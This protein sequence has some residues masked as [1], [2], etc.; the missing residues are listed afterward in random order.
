MTTAPET[1]PT[2]VRTL[3]HIGDLE[4]RLVAEADHGPSL[5]WMLPIGSLTWTGSRPWRQGMPTALEIEHAIEQVEDAVMPLL[6]QLPPG[7]RLETRDVA[8]RVLLACVREAVAGPDQVLSLDDVEHAFNQLAALSM[9]RPLASSS[10]PAHAGLAAY[11]VILREAMHHL[12]FASMA[13][14]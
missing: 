9:G 6:R 10:W 1:P 13:L 8:A 3:L 11:L 7:T 14:V 4:T 5:Q 2:A 12:R